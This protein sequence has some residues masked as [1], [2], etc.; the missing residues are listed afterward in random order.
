[1]RAWGF[2]IYTLYFMRSN[3]KEASNILLLSGKILDEVLYFF[4]WILRDVAG[5]LYH[6]IN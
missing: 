3:L 5:N 4:P 6:S 1:M 2:L